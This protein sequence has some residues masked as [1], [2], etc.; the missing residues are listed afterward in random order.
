VKIRL[1]VLSA[2]M[3][4][5]AIPSLG[6]AA[7]EKGDSKAGKAK[8]DALCVGCHG[9]TGKGDGPAAARLNP[10]PGD[11]TNC[12]EMKKVSDDTLHKTIKEGGKAVNKSSTM[13]P[14]GAALK[15]QQIDDVVSYLRSFC[16]K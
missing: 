10:K 12:T 13:P 8:Y 15:D 2:M 3:L 5:L 11:F 4:I 16:K 9:A 6:A 1:F 14:W 7:G